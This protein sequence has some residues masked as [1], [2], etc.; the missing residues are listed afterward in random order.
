MDRPPIEEFLI[1]AKMEK[2]EGEKGEEVFLLPNESR[3]IAQCMKHAESIAQY[4]ID[5]EQKA[6]MYKELFEATEGVK[7]FMTMPRDYYDDDCDYEDKYHA[8]L[9]RYKEAERPLEEENHD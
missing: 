7:H 2:F 1:A 6:A 3:F 5:K 9:K 4:A 8:A